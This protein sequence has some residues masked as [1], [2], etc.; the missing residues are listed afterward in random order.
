MK[1]YIAIEWPEAQKFQD[2]DEVDMK[3]IGYDPIKGIWFVPE[4]IYN[5]VY[6]SK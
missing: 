3:E 5:K 4:D 6:N 1:K 2:N